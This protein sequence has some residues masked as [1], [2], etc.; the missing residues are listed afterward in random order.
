MFR[1][2]PASLEARSTPVEF[3]D[4]FPGQTGAQGAAALRKNSADKGTAII[5]STRGRPDIVHSLVKQ[6]GEQTRP[7]E[8]IFIIASKA[9]DV[10]LLDQSQKNLTVRI[11]RPG[12][13]FQRNDGLALAGS[14]YSTI[15]F[16]DDD[17]VPSRFWLERMAA[18]FAARPDVAGLT[19]T[20]LADGTR[21]EGIRLDDAKSMVWDHDIN[22]DH[23]K[24]LHEHFAY[25]S[26]VGCNMAYRYAAIR[27]IVFDERLPLYAWHEDSDFRGQVERR[28]LFVKADE[29]WGVHLGH[30]QGRHNGLTLGYSQIANAVYL[31]RKGNVPARFLYEIATK[32]VIANTLRSLRPEPFVDRRGRLRGNLIALT[33]LMRGRLAPDRILEL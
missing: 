26:N 17:F 1:F 14:R 28:G 27:D 20:M 31:A 6:L 8:H 10:A 12:S 25:G 9:E 15:V 22:P 19:G 2:E 5:V 23:G 11:G 32:N 16:F 33:D 29:L 18:I 4:E 13:T 7:P 3:A 21:T 24:E 30:K